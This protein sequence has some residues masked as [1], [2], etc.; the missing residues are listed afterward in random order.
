MRGYGN[1]ITIFFTR[2]LRLLVGIA[3]CIVK[4]IGKT[5]NLDC[6]T[7]FANIDHQI[8]VNDPQK[9]SKKKLSSSSKQWSMTIF[10]S[11]SCQYACLGGG[12][13]LWKKS[14]TPFKL[15]FWIFNGAYRTGVP[16]RP[17]IENNA[18]IPT[19]KLHGVTNSKSSRVIEFAAVSTF[20]VYISS[21]S[22]EMWDFKSKV[23][24]NNCRV[25]RFDYKPGYRPRDLL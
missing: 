8:Y 21:T 25:V 6:F 5:W 18:I 4:Q 7:I 9:N 15:H 2:S 20:L 24:P 22:F 19:S 10:Q 13:L 14:T 16:L 1:Y 11:I 12:C 23:L 3:I 17:F